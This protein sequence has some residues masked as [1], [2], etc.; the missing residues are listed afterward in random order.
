M[1]DRERP[2]DD[3]LFIQPW[4]YRWG[5]LFEYSITAYWV[6]GHAASLAACDRLLA[7]PDLPE[8]YREQTRT[9]REFAVRKLVP[10]PHPAVEP[11]PHAPEPAPRA[12]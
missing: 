2:P 5:L 11:A 12:R 8:P 7:L 1:V 6:G 9:N 10:A 4:V 3:L